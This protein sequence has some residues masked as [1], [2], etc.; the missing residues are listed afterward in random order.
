MILKHVRIQ[1]MF[2]EGLGRLMT[3]LHKAN[4]PKNM[5]SQ[6]KKW[7]TYTYIVSKS[8]ILLF[9]IHTR[10]EKAWKVAAVEEINIPLLIHSV[11][12]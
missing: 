8:Y 11:W 12:E 10:T 1:L 5:I 4:T 9:Y 2:M 3:L 7:I 6:S